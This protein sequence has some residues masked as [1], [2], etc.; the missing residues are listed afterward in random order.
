MI[1]AVIGKPGHGKTLYSLYAMMTFLRAGW[2]VATNIEL[3]PAC[4]FER[5]VF[6]LGGKDYPVFQ[7]PEPKSE[8]H[9]DGLPYKAFWHYMPP[10]TA[11]VLDE[12]DNDFDS[13][14][15]LKFAGEAKD[16]RLYFKQHR[17]REDVLIY[18][19]QSIDNLWNRIR[20][21]TE[22]FVCCEY[23]FRTSP[24]IRTLGRR[25]SRFLRAEYGSEQLQEKD[26]IADGYF[27]FAEGREMFSW[28]RTNQLIGDV[29]RY[30][31]SKG[32]AA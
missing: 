4:P 15:F 10:R 20:R 7:L 29:G 12:L 19:V 21:M 17:K 8:W 14:E 3:L 30:G 23:N 13:L 9:P 2:R 31:W 25:W 26:R 27:T 22:T 5:R 6:F 24:L 28:Y 11:Y 16:A 32:G 1:R 18:T